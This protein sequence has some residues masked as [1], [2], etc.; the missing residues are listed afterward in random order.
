MIDWLI[1]NW[2]ELAGFVTGAACVWLLVI[3]NIWTFPVG[4]VNYV[5]F[6]VLFVQ[7]GLYADAGLQGVYFILASLGWYWWLRGGDDHQGVEV[8]EASPKVLIACGVAVI[9]IA[10][11]IQ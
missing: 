5:F 11:L 4:M 7:S 6:A 9:V 1:A 3:R 2:I 10:A 8:H